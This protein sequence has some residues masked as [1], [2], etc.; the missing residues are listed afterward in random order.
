MKT[1]SLPTPLWERSHPL[2]QSTNW[3]RHLLENMLQRIA[4]SSAV[5]K[6]TTDALMVHSRTS[7]RELKGHRKTDSEKEF[8]TRATLTLLQSPSNVH[9]SLRL[10]L[11]AYT[12]CIPWGYQS[13]CI[14]FICGVKNHKVSFFEKYYPIFWA[15][16][17]SN[18]ITDV[19][20]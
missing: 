6:P 8:L 11:T 16:I 1:T 9:S 4:C 14:Y 18:F 19:W 17:S 20:L 5:P 3:N 13:H 7:N 12:L 10:R 2:R 15:L